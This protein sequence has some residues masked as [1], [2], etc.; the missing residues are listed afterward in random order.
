[1][2][3]PKASNPIITIEQTKLLFDYLVA[4]CPNLVVW[5]A[6]KTWV[7]LRTSEADRFRYEWIDS[8]QK[9]V[10]IPGW[11]WVEGKLVQV[12][13]TQDNWEIHDLEPCFWCW[14]QKYK[15]ADE[16]PIS[17]PSRLCWNLIKKHLKEKAGLEK[18]PSNA[19]RN[20]FC[21][22]HISLYRDA[23]KTA[24]VLKHTS[25]R[26]LYREYLGNLVPKEKAQG[27]FEIVP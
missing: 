21:T 10:I 12:A 8:E 23:N 15:E 6:L 25:P 24:L 22:Y 11:E 13:K 5:F 16:G 19:L 7:G 18:W 4:E 17:K 20:S 1:M 2:K 26:T 3:I 27:Y 9:R 14:V